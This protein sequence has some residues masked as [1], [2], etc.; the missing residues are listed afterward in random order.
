MVT[1]AARLLVNSPEPI[2]GERVVK[3]HAVTAPNNSAKAVLTVSANTDLETLEQIVDDALRQSKIKN[4]TISKGAGGALA[5]TRQDLLSV[6][7]AA[8]Y[9]GQSENN[10]RKLIGNGELKAT[11][12]GARWLIAREHLDA[13]AGNRR[14]Y[15]RRSAGATGEGRRRIGTRHTAGDS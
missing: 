15:R 8:A 4:Y 10:I 12:S 3:E 9:L 2:S 13:I 6:T 14:S 5:A 11:K 1:A 7:E